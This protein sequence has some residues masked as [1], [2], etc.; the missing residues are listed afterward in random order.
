MLGVW[1]RHLSAKCCSFWGGRGVNDQ[2]RSATSP[3]SHP[4]TMAIGGRACVIRPTGIGRNPSTPSSSAGRAVA[5]LGE[6]SGCA[7]WRRVARCS[8]SGHA[9][10]HRSGQPQIGC[11]GN[12]AGNFSFAGNTGAS[13]AAGRATPWGGGGA[14]TGLPSVA[15]RLFWDGRT[16]TIP[17]FGLLLWLCSSCVYGQVHPTGRETEADAIEQTDAAPCMPEAD[18]RRLLR[19]SLRGGRQGR[20]PHDQGDPGGAESEALGRPR[21]Q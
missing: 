1:S 8:E 10:Q 4:A 12:F 7:W 9:S 21:A 2:G 5:S 18:A 19:P 3:L 6:R 20:R 17:S 11:Q 14:D 16:T 13:G 15:P